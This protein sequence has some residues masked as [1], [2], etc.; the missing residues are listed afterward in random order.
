MDALSFLF[1]SIEE[2]SYY[3]VSGV[4]AEDLKNPPHIPES[5]R[6]NTPYEIYRGFVDRP[7]NI[8]PVTTEQILSD[9]RDPP[10]FPVDSLLG[11]HVHGTPVY[12]DRCFP[13]WSSPLIEETDGYRKNLK[14]GFGLIKA[15]IEHEIEDRPF[16]GCHPDL[17]SCVL[18]QPITYVEACS[19]E[20]EMPEIKIPQNRLACMATPMNT[21]MEEKVYP[22]LR[23]IFARPNRER[24]HD[25]LERRL[26][27]YE[28]MFMRVADDR[29]KWREDRP[30]LFTIWCK[31]NEMY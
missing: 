18:L 9:N 20:E 14:R 1:R 6:R 30:T 24:P 5:V 22:D 25:A 16:S 31:M 23:K 10:V 28:D 2:L 11:E 27:R 7:L 8:C 13:I 12:S 3:K 29:T 15:G 4:T 17:L 19:T 26:E 21:F